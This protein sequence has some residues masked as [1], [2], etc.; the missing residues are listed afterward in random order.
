MNIKSKIYHDKASDR[1]YLSEFADVDFPII[2]EYIH[3]LV[4]DNN[5]TK[6]FA[7]IPSKFLPAFLADGYQIEAFIPDL[8]LTDDAAFLGKYYDINRNIRSESGLTILQNLISQGSKEVN[9]LPTFPIEILNH[10]HIPQMVGIF[11]E[12]FPNYPFPISDEKFLKR[13]MEDRETVY[14]G[15]FEGDNIIA[16]SSAEINDNYKFAEMTDF[17]VLPSHRGQKLALILLKKMEEMLIAEK[18]KMFFTIARLNSPSMNKTFLNNGY[19]YSGTLN[20]N[21]NISTGIE[22]M[23]ILYKAANK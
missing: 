17:A 18:Y 3:K 14:F 21:T 9:N 2:L 11:S 16:I 12:V 15:A 10:S 8:Y 22:S 4:I 1:V 5:Y 6:V 19:R 13:N 20:N 7:K 23:N